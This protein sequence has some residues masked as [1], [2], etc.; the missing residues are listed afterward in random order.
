M[1]LQLIRQQS[2]VLVLLRRQGLYVPDALCV[3]VHASVAGE[4]SHASYRGDRLR[5]PLILV[6]VCFVYKRLRLD[7][8]MEVVRNEVVVS[9]IFNATD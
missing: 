9:M 8:A 2:T 4:E 5:C 6:L 3:L 1:H 7:I